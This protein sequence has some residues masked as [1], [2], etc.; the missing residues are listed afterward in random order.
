M[1]KSLTIAL[2]GNANVGKSAIFNQLTGLNQIIGNWPGKTVERAEGTLHYKGYNINILDLPGIYSLT[3]FSLEEL[4]SRE[5]I[6]KEKPD[7]V[8]NVL[9]ATT[10]ERNLFFTLQLLE[11]ETPL[12]IALNQIDLAEKKGLIINHERMQELLGVPVVPTVAIKGI[13]IESLIK[14]AIETIEKPPL[15]QVKIKYG[16]EVEERIEKISALTSK[17]KLKIEYPSRWVAIKLLEG[18]EEVIK[19]VEAIDPQIIQ[20]ARSHAREIED[21]H[22]EPCSVVISSERYD[23]ASKIAREVQRII[24]PKKARFVDRIDNLIMHKIW[25]YLFLFALMLTI[26]YM[27]FTLGNTLSEFIAN[28]FEEIKTPVEIALGGGVLFKL[29]WEGILEG[30]IAGITIALPYII[31]FYIFLAILEDSGYLPRAAFMMDNFMHKIG[32]HGKAFIPLILGYGCNVP[33]CLGCRIME[34]T[35]ERLIAAFITTLVPC[36][37]RTIVILGLVST[38]VGINWAIALYILNLLLIFALG[39]VAFKALPGEPVG[40]IM[41]I[42]AYRKPSLKIVA[43]QSWFRVKDFISVAFPLII[44]GSLSIKILELANLLESIA[45]LM[46]PVTVTWLGLP[47]LTGVAFILGVLRKELT[48]IMLASLFGTSNFSLVLTQKQMIVFALVTMLYIPC[49]ATI[50]ALIKELDW[51][52]ALF[53]ALFEIALAIFIGGIAYRILGFLY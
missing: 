12:V 21:I 13:G 24:A 50:A 46:S 53:I 34:T 48:L 30:V 4:V 29:I 14:K 33:A 20:I 27:V 47:S 52:K 6:A 8:I 32:L 42:P 36:S 44:I 18:D 9:D 2:A 39:R 40:L 38:F 19:L 43:K 25:G 7:L 31:P 51:R 45:N 22:G 10:L 49:I 5:Y 3:T 16:K 1:E 28:S 17:L 26:F 11:L 15:E 37:A 41:E 23:I 35:R